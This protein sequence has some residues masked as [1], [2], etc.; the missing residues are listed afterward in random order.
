MRVTIFGGEDG[1]RVK[2]PVHMNAELAGKKRMCP[3]YINVK[4]NVP[5]QSNR[6]AQV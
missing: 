1:L 3:L 6:R 5:S 4:G 2:K